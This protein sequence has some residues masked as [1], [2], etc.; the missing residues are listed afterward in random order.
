MTFAHDD[1]RES[2]NHR[3][4]I[5]LSFLELNQTVIRNPNNFPDCIRDLQNNPCIGYFSNDSDAKYN[6]NIFEE[7]NGSKKSPATVAFLGSSTERNARKIFD[8]IASWIGEYLIKR[9]VIWYRK[10]DGNIYFECIKKKPEVADVYM[11]GNAIN[12]DK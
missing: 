2:K 9:L 11:P 4:D 12:K 6:C 5:I 1:A 3:D 10:H 8:Y 7:S